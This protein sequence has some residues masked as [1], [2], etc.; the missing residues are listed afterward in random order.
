MNV[1]SRR[2]QIIGY[3]PIYVSVLPSNLEL[4]DLGFYLSNELKSFAI[5]KG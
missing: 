1:G 3:L 5:A 4:G 2:E